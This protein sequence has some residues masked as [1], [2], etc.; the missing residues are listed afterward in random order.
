MYLR[1]TLVPALL[2]ALPAI[3]AEPK[4][5]RVTLSSGGV[6]QYEFT[7]HLDGPGGVGLEIPLDQVD[8]LL[9]S[10]RIDDPAGAAG[11]VRLPGRQPIA[12]AFRT[13]PITQDALTSP[14]ALL[15]ALVGAEVRL[16][17]ASL[18]GAI[19][20]VTEMNAKLPDGSVL[21]R[22]RLA[23]AT[24]LGIASAVLED[25]TE[26]ELTSAPLRAQ[27][28][29]ALAA[30]ADHRTQNRRT[31]QVD[32]PGTGPRDVR[33]GYVVA[34][35]IWKVSYRLTLPANGPGRLQG[36]AI[37]ENLSGQDWHGVD[38]VLTSGQ[39]VL[40]RQSLY[41]AVFA[42]RPDLPLQAGNSA[43]PQVDEG[44]QPPAPP[45]PAPMG[46]A[47]AAA[48]MMAEMAPGQAM[49]EPANPPPATVDQA[50]TQVEFHITAPVDASAGQSLLLPILDRAVPTKRV[51]LFTPEA[52]LHPFVAL[53]ITNDATSALPPGL[54][55]LYRDTAAPRFVGDAAL[56]SMQPGEDRLLSF[57]TDLS[58]RVTKT[59]S[60]DSVIVSGHAAR[61]TLTIT[62]RDRN[63]TTYRVTTAPGE[64]RNLLIEQPIREGWTVTQPAG[65]S[66]TPTRWR[67][68][69]EIPA[70]TTQDVAVVTEH[71]RSQT[72]LVGKLTPALLAEY[73]GNAALDPAARAAFVQAGTLRVDLDRQHDVLTGITRQ[74]TAIVADQERVRANLASTTT[75][76]ALQKRY[77]AMLQQ[78]EDTLSNLH[79]QQDNAQAA[80][81]KQDAALKDYLAGMIF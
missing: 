45:A 30:I 41:E 52:G 62:W 37:V 2:I 56:P 79:N 48:P 23:I 47:R 68:A 78:Q 40:F 11:A 65:A 19:L 50:A 63:V 8:D 27:L 36:Y 25:Q 13:L 42:D 80:L 64:A 29:T 72:M 59:D 20:S 4:L 22:H 75:N 35:P 14:E 70:G 6:G 67:I 1:L 16:P 46:K 58:T 71:P 17:S 21:T 77:T 73:A 33:L 57:A 31:V 5:V 28:A 3:A 44:A 18:T 24:A 9:A 12:E 34:A 10:L 74:I 39:P 76:Q 54:T 38:M 51:A 60:G 55:T 69:Q 61:G 66:R 49:P 7:A 81:D 15:Q 53:Q 43:V 26:V 32:L